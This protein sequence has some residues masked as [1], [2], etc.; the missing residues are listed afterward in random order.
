MT[1]ET[2]IRLCGGYTRNV[3]NISLQRAGEYSRGVVYRNKE[4]KEVEAREEEEREKERER[5]YPSV[6]TAASYVDSPFVCFCEYAKCEN[7]L[8]CTGSFLFAFP[9]SAAFAFVDPHTFLSL[10]LS[11]PGFCV[12]V[13]CCDF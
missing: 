7:I 10:S 4:K 5:T 9:F 1:F 3:M 12:R 2:G 13:R 11:L 6:R 8:H